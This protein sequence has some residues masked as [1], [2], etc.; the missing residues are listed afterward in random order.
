MFD[1]P[2]LIQHKLFFFLCGFRLN[3]FDNLL[4]QRLMKN[5]MLRRSF[6]LKKCHQPT[7]LLRRENSGWKLYLCECCG[8]TLKIVSV[9][10]WTV[11]FYEWI[12]R[13]FHH[14]GTF[15]SLEFSTSCFSKASNL[16]L[17]SWDVKRSDYDN[18]LIG[19]ASLDKRKVSFP[20]HEIIIIS[21]RP[22]LLFWSKRWWI[23]KHRKVL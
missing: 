1:F 22:K 15:Y 10:L 8:W 20:M 7:S 5:I 3:P 11:I 9:T 14:N 6:I 21:F 2:F 16:T 4:N 19:S 12:Q 13:Y 23:F 18:D 17:S